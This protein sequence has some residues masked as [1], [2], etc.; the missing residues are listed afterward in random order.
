M[1][2]DV[3]SQKKKSLVLGLHYFENRKPQYVYYRDV[4]HS[5]KEMPI[6]AN[7]DERVL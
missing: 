6:T 5:L 4:S 2:S 7:K 3:K 1:K